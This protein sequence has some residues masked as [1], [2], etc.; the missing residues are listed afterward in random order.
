MHTPSS[1]PRL[2]RDPGV[3]LFS[4]L[5]FGAKSLLACSLLLL[6]VLLLLAWQGRQQYQDAMAAH[7]RAV[8]HHVEVAHKVLVWAHG[9]ETSG[10]V[11]RAAAQQLARSAVA[12]LRY[13]QD[14][15]FWINDLSA[16]MVMHPVKPELDG[17]DMAGFQDPNGQHVF[18]LFAEVA[19]R[20]GQGLVAYQWSKPGMATPQD[21]ISYVKAFQ[22]W[23]WVIGTG[24]YVDQ[25]WAEAKAA[26]LRQA[27]VVALA[28]LLGFYGFRSFHVSMRSGLQAAVDAA[29]AVGGGQ[30]D[31]AIPARAAHTE[32][33]RLLA[34]L[35]RMQAGLRQRHADDTA[36]LASSQAATEAARQVTADI[37]QAVDAAAA[38]DFSQRLVAQGRAPQHA[39]LC[40]KFNELIDTVSGTMAEV[41]SA[42]QQ[43]GSASAQVSQTAQSLAHSASQQAAGVEQTTASLHEISASVRQNADSATVT[44]GIATQAASEAM[45]GGQAVSQ[46][47]DAMKSIA[48]KIGIV[49]DIAYQT[50]LLALNAA[51]E[52]ARAGEHG[53]GFA[54]VAAEVRKLAERSQAAAREIGQLAGNSVGLA[55]RAGHLLERMVPS[56]HKTSE[57][58][59]EIA[60]ASGE[61]NTSVGQITGAMNHLNSTT[62]QAASASE[63][64][65]ATA[66]ELSAQAQ[67]LQELMAGFTLAGD[68]AAPPQPSPALRQAAGSPAGQRLRFG[69]ATGRLATA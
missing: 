6:P 20:Q 17:K 16:R 23:G 18:Q 13:G 15:Y 51:I 32:E 31:H 29:D 25:V 5:R 12:R 27:G 8:Q 28:L 52:A 39:A 57:L 2:P 21:K 22:P 10:A 30:L 68:L 62:Q 26:W 41:R 50:N 66:E 69:A 56:I 67:R 48:Q 64:L 43:L 14:D 63:E 58:V 40:S 54:V 60:A 42:A 61:Q 33:G 7:Q 24:V 37:S 46:T 38:G 55:E 45:E 35:G 9:L 1:A 65:S 19:K 49:D 47:V 36:H 53:K 4:H 59:Q 11:P 3:R 44:D 34:A